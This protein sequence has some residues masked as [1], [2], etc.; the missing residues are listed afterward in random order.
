[1]VCQ[2]FSGMQAQ[3][4]LIIGAGVGGLSAA[5]AL[6]S[7]GVGVTVLERAARP[8]GKMREVALTDGSRID[9]GPTVFTMRWVFDTLLDAA[10]TSLEAEV[11]LS[12]CSVLAR[13]AWSDTERLDLFADPERSAEA[14]GDF[15]GAAEAARFK[16]F[17]REIRQI[18]Q[19]LEGPFLKSSRPGPIQLSQRIGFS[20][21]PDL[22][23]LQPLSTMWGA[24]GKHFRDPRLQQ[25]FGRYAT[26]CGSSPYLA[27]AT[28][29]LVAHVEQDGVWMV[30]G[31]MYR[32]A[33]ALARV[34][35][36]L[37]VDIRC[38]SPVTEV[39]VERGRARGVMCADGTQH[40]ADAVIV[41][42]D[43]SAV[44][45]GL[46][47]E[48]VRKAVDAVP[49][50]ARSL[51]AIAW[52]LRAQTSG[53]PMVRHN[54]FFSRAYADEF[55]RIFR[56]HSLP[57]E[58]TTYICAQDRGDDP[59]QAPTGPERM[60]FILNAPPTGDQ[61][62]FDPAEIPPCLERCLT[63]LTRCGLSVTPEASRSVVTGP[64]EFNRLFPGTGG[65]LYG[66]A[67][68]GWMASF[69]RPDATTRLPGL[70][71]AGG[72]VHPGPG[73][74]MAALSGQLA[75][76]SVL[77][78]FASTSRSARMAMSGGMSMR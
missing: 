76:R 45:S 65:A 8:G 42:A 77:S 34:A 59:T 12:A 56:G 14:I 24:L 47:G 61:T 63:L 23:R 70:Y 1:M 37:G 13:H 29:M 54:V 35:T 33:E 68:H 30:E 27:P 41:N 67:S 10:G 73:V 31:G 78:G 19:T 15:A 21:L 75:A 43:A 6:A 60:L 52:T 53:F 32:L 20:R 25:L 39:L 2:E 18:Y 5:I 58:P 17:C 46:F 62:S 28:L 64:A 11:A 4:T 38:N 71:L 40:T 48:A 36:R 69:Q 51:S 66:R 57:H 22:M 49:L 16:G 3:R 7:A 44:G 55:E 74:P 50:P 72:S 9:G 26:Y